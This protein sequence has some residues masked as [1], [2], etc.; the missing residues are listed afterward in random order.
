MKATNYK[1]YNRESI[2]VTPYV[3]VEKELQGTETVYSIMLKEYGQAVHLK[4]E[5]ALLVIEALNKLFKN[6]HLDY[7]KK[8]HECVRVSIFGKIGK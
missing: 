2:K 6:K 1:E 3:E 8:E 5:T 4:P 7:K